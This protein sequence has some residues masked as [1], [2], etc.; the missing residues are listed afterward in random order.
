MKNLP[1]QSPKAYIHPIPTIPKQAPRMTA[2]PTSLKIN[3]NKPLSGDRI[4]GELES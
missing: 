3:A 4:G 2:M 1:E